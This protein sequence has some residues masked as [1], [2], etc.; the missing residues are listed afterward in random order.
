MRY[1]IAVLAT[2]VLA[3]CQCEPS[4]PA[5]TEGW[6]IVQLEDYAKCLKRASA[7]ECDTGVLDGKVA[8]DPKRA[9]P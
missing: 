2:L 4:K 5:S 3:G 7:S 6:K 1:A 9:K 8:P